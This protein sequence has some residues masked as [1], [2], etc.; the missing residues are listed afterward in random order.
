MDGLCDGN[1]YALRQKRLMS[2][3]SPRAGGEKVPEGTP[4]RRYSA[5]PA[6][7]RGFQALQLAGSRIDARVSL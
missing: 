3:P 5:D 7:M 4:D 6:G 1:T 2:W